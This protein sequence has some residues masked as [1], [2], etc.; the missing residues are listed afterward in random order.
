MYKFKKMTEEQLNIVTRMTLEAYPGIE[1]AP[2][3]Y[4]ERI[5]ANSNRPDVNYYTVQNEDGTAVATYNTWD[6]DNM[7]FRGTPIKVGGIGSVAVDLN[8]KKQGVAKAMLTHW[9]NGLPAQGRNFA[10]LYPFNSAF[11]HKMG[12]GFGIMGHQLRLKPTDLPCSD[13]VKSPIR[14]LNM[15]D[16]QAL[17]DYYN[18]KV[19]TTHGLKNKMVSEFENRLKVSSVKVFAFVEGDEI[20]GYLSCNFQRGSQSDFLSNDLV[21]NEMFFD[22]PAVFAGMMAFLR[23]QADQIRYIVINTQDEGFLQIPKDARNHTENTFLSHQEAAKTGRGIMYRV[24]DV[25]GFV[26][27]IANV[28]FGNLNLVLKLNLTDTFLPRNNKSW[29][30]EFVDGK[31]SVVEGKSHDAEIGIDVAEFSSLIMGCVSL[32]TLVKYGKAT[33]V[34]NTYLHLLNQAFTTPEKPVCTTF[35]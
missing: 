19:T 4:A 3:A 1:A 27:D 35:F 28:Q 18:K 29:L 6:F 2:D 33:L 20:Y 8:H 30:L 10:T 17:S 24:V 21:V 14:K 9:L 5:K 23:T 11:Y 26:K 31:M 12:F 32:V 7:N 15:D 34:T 22:S 16:A 13:G 25:A